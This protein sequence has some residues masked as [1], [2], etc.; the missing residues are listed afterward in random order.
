MKNRCFQLFTIALFIL[1][2]VSIAAADELPELKFEKFVLSNGLEVILHEDHTIPMVSVNVWYHVGSKNEKTGRTGFAHLFEHLMFEGSEHHNTDFSESINKYGGVDNGSTSED[3][4]NYWENVPSNYL[5]KM[6]W[7][8]SDRMGFLLPAMT[9]ERL[10]NQ[11]DVVKNERRYRMDNQPYAKSYEIMLSLMYP[12]DHPY[13]HSVIGSMDD[14]SAASLEDVKEFFK[15]YYVPNNASLSIAGDFN[16]KQAR[17]WVEK[18]FGPI[19]PGRPVDRIEQWVPQLTEIKRFSAEDNVSLPRVYMEWHTPAY[20]APGDAEFDLLAS[21][22]TSGKTSRLYKTLVYDKQ[23]AQDVSSSQ[24]SSE[25]SGTFDVTVTA[26]EGHTLE[27]I[28]REVDAILNDLLTNGITEAELKQAKTSWES[29][30]VR[31]LQTVGGF[32]GRANLLN[33]YNVFL[34]DPGKLN[35][36]MERYTNA[37]L[38][39]V[40]KYAREFINLDGRSILRIY[41]QGDLAAKEE[42]PDMTVSPGAGPEPSFNSPDIQTAT[43]SNG[44]Q[45]YLVEN[46]NL[47]LIQINLLIKSGW[48]AD[49]A[50]RPG[51]AALTADLLDE[52]TKKRNALQISDEIRSLGAHL[53]AGSGFDNSYVNLN[54]LKKNLGPALD[55]MADIVLNPTF[56]KEEMER[57]RENY[58]GRIAQESKRPFTIAYKIFNK[59]LFGEGHPY[60]QPYTGSGTEASIK[61]ITRSDL[62]SFYKANYLPNNAAFIV[63]G[64]ITLNEAKS[65]LEKAFKK[66]KS[67]EVTGTEIVDIEP[68]QE[69]K[70]YVLDKPG[71]AQS[72]IILGNPGLRRKDDDFLATTVMNNALGGQPTARLNM[73]IREDKGYTY[74]AFSV[75]TGRKA[76]GAYFAYA[77]V[78]T[79]VTKESLVEFM[80]EFRGVIGDNPITEEE[81]SESKD[82]LIKGFPQDFQT[83]GGIAGQLGSMITYDLSMDEWKTYVDR[84]NSIDLSKAAKAATDYISPESLLIVVVGD[85]EKVEAGIRELNLGEVI[86]LDSAIN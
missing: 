42:T 83:I 12:E 37:T 13:R 51:A 85:M 59:Q 77:E 25:I 27:E 72:V 71:A 74:G 52:G 8:E 34:G 38:E 1:A 81:L 43:L 79:E 53:G 29:S 70:V 33:S 36:D 46:H 60:A 69:T 65:K 62:E 7:L 47:P 54:T 30:F 24:S 9:Q 3:K 64:D 86:V 45:L 67:G 2:I 58:L 48:A 63:V 18:Y 49:P 31:R 32:G 35:W 84:V 82:N 20:Y 61:G 41:P 23:I 80:K 66:W 75:V 14:L 15:L 55:L 44:V 5:E 50:D 17:E 21:I 4:T 68:L 28:E 57:K 16:P 19:P 40:M 26:K 11:R 76:R 78:Q 56:P 6:L 22:L 10:D 73:N 39:S